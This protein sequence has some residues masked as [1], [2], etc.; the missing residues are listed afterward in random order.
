MDT[1]KSVSET[2]TALRDYCRAFINDELYDIPEV[3]RYSAT[4]IAD[5]Q[6]ELVAAKAKI[7]ELETKANRYDE[8]VKKLADTINDLYAEA[9]KM[10]ARDALLKSELSALQTHDKEAMDLLWLG[11]TICDGA[12]DGF[13]LKANLRAYISDRYEALK[14]RISETT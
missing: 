1:D 10:L 12:D 5:Q 7:V 8:K 9:K 11:K 3:A 14:A 13:I 4:L 2:I 6:S